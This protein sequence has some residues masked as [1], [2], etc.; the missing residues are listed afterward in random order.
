MARIVLS[1]FGSLGDLHPMI[2]L[3][4]GLRERG[5]E[6]VFATAEYYRP[7]IEELGFELRALRPHMTPDDP[8]LAALVMDAK[9][10]PENV[11]RGIIFPAL[12]DTFEDLRRAAEGADFLIAGELIYGAPVLGELTGLPWANALLAPISFFSEYDPPVPPPFPGLAKLLGKAR[13]IDRSIVRF[14]RFATRSWGQ[15]VHD[16]RRELGLP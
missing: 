8:E 7:K 10:G 4:L 2:A 14:G 6:P 13:W 1:T 11:L 9:K 12:R 15:P 3:A 16:L 5:H